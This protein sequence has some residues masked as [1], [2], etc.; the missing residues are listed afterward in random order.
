M[1]PTHNIARSKAQTLI[2]RIIAALV[3]LA[4][5]MRNSGRTTP[6]DGFD[7]T[8]SRAAIY[9]DVFNIG[10][11]LKHNAPYRFYNGIGAIIAGCNYCYFH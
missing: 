6:T 7:R 5:K 3:F 11:C 2:E 8:I 9:N 1:K 10:I 4:D